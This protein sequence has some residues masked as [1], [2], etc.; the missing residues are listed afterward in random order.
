MARQSSLNV[1][2]REPIDWKQIVHGTLNGLVISSVSWKAWPLAILVKVVCLSTF[3]GDYSSALTR[4]GLLRRTI[5]FSV[6]MIEELGFWV[7]SCIFPR[8]PWSL[9]NT[10]SP[11]VK[12][13][14]SIKVLQDVWH[15]S[16]KYFRCGTTF[17]GQAVGA[18]ASEGG[19]KHGQQFRAVIEKNLPETAIGVQFREYSAFTQHGQAFF[20]RTH[21]MS[22]ALHP[23]V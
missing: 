9:I 8:Q 11:L 15:G 4:A 5:L 19:D 2:V 3:E 21:G 17:K 10:E 18:K 20:N 14:D 23:F 7:R 16:P 22:F 13:Y 1:F 6:S 12:S